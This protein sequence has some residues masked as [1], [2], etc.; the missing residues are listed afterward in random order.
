MDMDK[1]DVP[2]GY[3]L[4]A[5]TSTI[6]LNS[7]V[8]YDTNADWITG[9]NSIRFNNGDGLY[10]DVRTSNN[11][12]GGGLGPVYA[13]YSCGSCHRNAGR[14][15]PTLWENGGSGNYGFSSMLVYISRRNGAFFRD[16]G[17]VLH[18]QAI[19]GVEPE[20]KV[21][22]ENPELELTTIYYMQEIRRKPGIGQQPRFR[23]LEDEMLTHFREGTFIV[24][25]QTADKENG[26]TE[27]K[28]PF[29]KMK[30]GDIYQPIFTDMPEFFKFCRD[31]KFRA[32]VIPY[33][34]LNA[35]ILK[36]AKGIIMNPFGVRLI[37]NKG[38]F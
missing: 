3:A 8:A 19:Y 21:K 15:K 36:Q 33:E 1:I 7:S 30:N 10:D 9:A 27:S 31:G 23:E 13:G 11:G 16:Y 5:G 22:V 17:R 32:A 25:V 12:D 24:P 26:E 38:Q 35:V 29:M 20:G 37:L 6:F 18:D 14:T 28:V 34:K 4:S 2:N